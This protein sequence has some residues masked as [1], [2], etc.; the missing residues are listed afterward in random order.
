M[1][2]ANKP[3]SERFI[4]DNED[5]SVK[6]RDFLT[7]SCEVSRAYD[8]ATGYFEIGALLS[9]SEKW[10]SLEK[11]RILLGDE[12]SKRTER[13]FVEG[14]SNVKARLDNSLETEKNKNEFLAG[15]PAIVEAIKSGQI[16]CRVYRKDKFHAKCYI[17][18][19]KF[20][21]VG[22]AALVGSSN[23]TYPGLTDNVELNV[24]I[25]GTDVRD[26]QEW[27]ERHW[28]DAVD[29]TPDILRV[30]TRHTDPLTPFEIWFKAL[31]ELLRT[32][33]LT[34]DEWDSNQS[35]MFPVLDKYQKDAYRML[36]SIAKSYGGAFLCDGV[37]LGKTYVGLMLIERFMVHEKKRVVLF[38]PKAAID[39]VWAP[40]ISNQLQNWKSKFTSLVQYS[41]TDLQR[42]G[43]WPEEM[44]VTL[45]D[46]DVIVIDEAHHF[47]NPGVKGEGQ[48]R[49]AS[50]YRLLQKY[51]RQGDSK[52]QVFLLTATPINNS[53]DDFRHLI[54]LFDEGNDQYFH[55]L[56]IHSIQGHFKELKKNLEQRLGDQ[57][58][59]EQLAT[60]TDIIEAEKLLQNNDLFQTLVVQRSRAYVKESQKQSGKGNQVT[61]PERAEPSTIKYS[62]RSSYG[63]LLESVSTAF[64]RDKPLFVL[65][66]YYPLD[67]VK[68]E[69]DGELFPGVDLSFERGRQQQVVTLIRTL[70][71][72]RFESSSRAFEASCW[73]LLVKLM[74]WVEVHAQTE[75]E[76]RRFDRWKT[77]NARVLSQSK[78][79]HAKAMAIVE[80]DK[81]DSP[82][83]ME[84]DLDLAEQYLT[85]EMLDAVDPL[86]R[87]LYDI[88]V[89]LDDT[90]DD[91]N[92]LVEFIDHASAVLPER[93]YKL[94]ELIK[95][96]KN[97]PVLSTEKALIFSEFA[98]TARYIERELKAAGIKGVERIDGASTRKQRSNAIKRFSPYYNG[99]SSA[100]VAAGGE[101]EI[102][103]LISTDVLSEGLNLQDASRMINYDIHW[104]PVRLMQRIGRVDRRMN[105]EIEKQILHDHPEQLNTRGYV[106]FWNFLPPDELDQLLRLFQ[107]VAR[108]TLV[109]SRTFGIE[110]RKL[111]TP[112][113]K[114][115]PIKELNEQFDG[116]LSQ[117]ES[118]RLEYMKL[119]A[120]N[121]ALLDKVRTL[122]KKAF[123]GKAHPEEGSKAIFFCYRIPRLDPSLADTEKSGTG[124]SHEAGFAYWACY[125]LGSKQLLNDQGGI[126]KLIRSEPDTQRLTTTKRETLS[127]IRRKVEKQLTNDHLK[128]LQ[129][130]VGVDLEL[131]C[132]IELN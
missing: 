9:M 68:G 34:S 98:E 58:R 11:I 47:R 119:C 89:M 66:I 65:G 10:Q 64:D 73:R 36:I 130:P 14:L 24:Q 76:V 121:P 61:F 52:K 90:L 128:S 63:R 113:D 12:V 124:W 46:A 114:F 91:M 7:E 45:K 94:Q 32:E 78:E 118:L 87:G 77:K 126:A 115:D 101:E 79:R 20:A 8:I 97:D 112:D 49:S 38:A 25:K 5:A 111:L 125:D 55:S 31:D 80:A 72:K 100:Q 106:K 13:A 57:V 129:A 70:F 3:L 127:E 117:V 28:N 83:T 74:A 82:K 17:T 27:Y 6:V 16:E 92:Q 131:K 108:K 86:D 33:P 4:V 96:M 56:G 26:L 30:L 42:K 1:A 35:V 69:V 18:H 103:I 51:L 60:G 71:L 40:A 39:D 48:V 81:N 2:Q 122:P 54:G 22:S 62:L 41:H 44:E 23:F 120:A 102:R 107:R 116:T 43:A 132:W 67:Y 88:P 110:G 53:L 84:A 123:S 85:E 105:P 59:V 104:N 109:I 15:V 19:S 93:D 29:V 37:G 75:S 95:L 21:A 99:S 50:R